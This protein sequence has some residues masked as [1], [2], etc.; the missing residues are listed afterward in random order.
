MQ[1]HISIFHSFGL[2][3]FNS[4]LSKAVIKDILN[5]LQKRNEL[6]REFVSLHNTSYITYSSQVS[7]SQRRR[8]GRNSSPCSYQTSYKLFVNSI[9]SSIAA[10][11]DNSLFSKQLSS[12]W[13]EHKCENFFGNTSFQFIPTNCVH[14]CCKL[15]LLAK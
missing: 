6:I 15:S 4:A 12:K 7:V 2:Y 1:E 5:D 10:I 9:A 11:K 14:F 13:M 8:V 3:C